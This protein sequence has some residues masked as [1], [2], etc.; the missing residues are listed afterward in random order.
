MDQ[1]AS[2]PAR[3]HGMATA[4]KWQRFVPLF[5]PWRRQAGSNNGFSLALLLPTS[6][7]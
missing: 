7:P 6:Q 2:L 3:P 1:G 4:A 5:T